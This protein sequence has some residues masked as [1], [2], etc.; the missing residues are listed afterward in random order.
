MIEKL[1][2]RLKL[3]Y[4]MID[5]IVISLEDLIVEERVKMNCFYCGRYGLSW[6][7]PPQ[8]PSIDYMK[9]FSEYENGAIV[10]G[11][12]AYVPN[13]YNEVR[14][15]S[16]IILHK[17]LLELEKEL[18]KNNNSLAISF[19]GGSCKLCKN[20]CGKERC[21]NPYMARTPVEATGV[22]IVNLAKKYDI[23]IKFPPED[24]IVRA[25]LLLW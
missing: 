21:N 15:E 13:R 25:G 17:A 3:E 20:G 18:W 6:K 9:L 10:Y 5:I 7:C 24:A 16:S 19:I 11:K 8:I 22:N 1:T 14:S 12:F 4:P 23:D 2:N